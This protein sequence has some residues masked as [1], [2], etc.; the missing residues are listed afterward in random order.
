M[1]QI[2]RLVPAAAILATSC[3]LSSLPRIEAMPTFWNADKLVHLVCF[4]GLAFWLAFGF[5]RPVA[6]WR[7]GNR[8]WLWLAPVLFVAVYGAVDEIHQS[9]TP[10]RSCSLF[11]WCADVTGSML[12]SYAHLLLVSGSGAIARLWRRFAGLD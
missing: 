1:L 3:V 2:L 8:V 4:G 10:G 7:P 12:G 6:R 5:C 9:F 11:D